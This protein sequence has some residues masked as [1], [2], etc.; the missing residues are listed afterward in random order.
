ML[1]GN[2]LV[3]RTGLLIDGEWCEG[4]EPLLV[5]DKYTGDTVAELRGAGAAEADAAV[6]AAARAAARPS[7]PAWR[8][9]E[10]LEAAADELASRADAVV[11]AYVAETGFTLA[12]ARTEL[13]RA[14]ET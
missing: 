10:I 13:R 2:A 9:A 11:A 7:I 8:R 3:D 5:R 12:D 4:G 1:P 6:G 14:C